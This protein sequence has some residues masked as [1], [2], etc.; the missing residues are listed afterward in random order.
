MICLLFIL[1]N[2]GFTLRKI[3]VVVV[4]VVHG[5]RY[6]PRQGGGYMIFVSIRQ[7]NI[8]CRS[9]LSSISPCNFKN[10]FCTVITSANVDIVYSCAFRAL[11]VSHFTSHAM[12]VIRVFSKLS[13]SNIWNLRQFSAWPRGCDIARCN[14]SNDCRQVKS[15]SLYL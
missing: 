4:V 6:N 11:T 13:I 14:V 10:Y 12:K 9:C 2:F 1:V 3:K 15:I 7:S 5:I 8:P